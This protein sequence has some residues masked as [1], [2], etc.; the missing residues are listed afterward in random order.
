M[1][2][3]STKTLLLI[4]TLAISFSTFSRVSIIY[5]I[6][7][8]TIN[9]YELTTFS[10]IA[11]EYG[12]VL[13]ISS[14]DDLLELY[15]DAERIDGKG[16]AM[17]PGL[18]DSYTNMMQSV[19]MITQVD[20]REAKSI[21][22][23][24]KK[25]Q[26][27]ID[28]H[29][30]A[31]W[32]QGYG[33]DHQ[34]W[35]N[36]Q[37]PTYLD[38]DKLKTN[39]PI[40]LKAY[41]KKMGWANSK[42][43]K[44]ARAAKYRSNPRGGSVIFDRNG[45]HTG[46]YIDHALNIISPHIPDISPDEKYNILTKNL[47]KL[48][49]LGITG[50]NDTGADYRTSVIYKALASNDKLPIR[51]NAIISSSEK[52][53]KY[54]LAKGPYHEENQFLHIHALKY[55]IDGE[56]NTYDAAMFQPY[57]DRKSSSG[58]IRQPQHFLQENIYKNAR[59]G[60]Q[61]SIH[62]VGDKANNI[63]LEVLSDEKA[64][65]VELRHR[66][67]RATIIQLKDFEK[68]KDSHLIVSIQ[69]NKA[70][71]EIPLY[72]KRIGK[73]RLRGTHAWQ[74]LIKNSATVISGSDFP[75]LPANPFYG[76]HAAV[77]RQTRNNNPKPS[78]TSAEKM[79]VAQALATYTINAA[80]ANRQE[81]SLGGLETGKWADFILLDQ[82]IFDIDPG[83]IWKTKVLQTWVAGKKIYD[84]KV[85]QEKNKIFSDSLEKR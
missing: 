77:N 38:L 7:G 79:T 68:F 40:W 36:Q 62:A 31:K 11:F 66:I 17:L 50:L 48:S 65:T 23:A 61:V 34:K 14:K 8:H 19:F 74:S 37:L 32:I 56:L 16:Q 35:P 29:P 24:L 81:Q 51:V 25:I 46:I 78:W 44:I 59:K 70:I 83:Q 21:D 2:S 18:H 84:L 3:I 54:I 64:K 15:P 85:L 57:L 13:K 43:M 80:Y 69:P 1:K 82:D 12:R 4:L 76:I 63:A 58:K 71:A 72:K 39:K 28:K 27:F 6:K 30:K 47:A 33:W 49:S 53:L 42:A 5:N 41:N 9:Q 22:E 67:E 55:Y 73:Q 26:N 20:L 75:Q 45:K 10:S 60:W 52:K